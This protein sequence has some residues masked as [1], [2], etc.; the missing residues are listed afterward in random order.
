MNLLLAVFI[1]VNLALVSKW[2][3]KRRHQAWIR[4]RAQKMRAAMDSTRLEIG[5]RLLPA[6]LEVT[7]AM[8][9]FT[10]AAQKTVEVF[11]NN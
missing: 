9:D 2:Q 8:S 7:K 1:V 5:K 3:N 4:E 6:L 11:K 10:Y